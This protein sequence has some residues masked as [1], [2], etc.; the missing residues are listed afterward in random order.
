MKYIRKYNSNESIKKFEHY[1]TEDLKSRFE[2][3]ELQD[4]IDYKSIVSNPSG[5]DKETDFAVM[6]DKLA[7]YHPFLA[8]CIDGRSTQC[9]ARDDGDMFKYWFDNGD[10]FVGFSVE[11]KSVGVYD[12]SIMFKDSNVKATDDNM[13][14][15]NGPYKDDKYYKDRVM[16]ED[17]EGVSFKEMIE[18]VIGTG[19]VDLLQDLGMSDILDNKLATEL[20]QTYRN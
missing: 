1:D 13:I 17:Y 4:L 14:I 10:W 16:I 19:V 11:K 18:G 12:C 6:H 7:T 9:G 3:Q 15:I 5:L 20:N 2:I 8:Q